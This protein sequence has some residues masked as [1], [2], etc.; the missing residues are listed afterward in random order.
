MS[1]QEVKVLR[2]GRWTSGE[3]HG[4]LWII[5]QNW[6]HYYEDFYDEG[7]DLNSEG[8]AYYALYG[9]GPTVDFLGARSQTFLSEADAIA[10]AEQAFER[11]TWTD[12]L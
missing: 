11:V 6:D 8:W 2:S 9:T 1:N 4:F 7:P 3:G 10:E 12:D 5:R